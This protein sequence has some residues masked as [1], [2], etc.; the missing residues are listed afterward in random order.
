MD[1]AS[2][3]SR[4]ARLTFFEFG[5]GTDL[6]AAFGARDQRIAAIGRQPNQVVQLL[7]LVE[8]RSNG[9]AD[10]VQIAAGG[11]AGDGRPALAGLPGGVVD[12]VFQ[13]LILRS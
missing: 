8:R 6:L 7:A 12:E 9:V 2:C 4:S 11:I 1:S 3:C 10:A 13:V 5:L